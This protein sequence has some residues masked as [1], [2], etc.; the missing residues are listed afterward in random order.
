MKR[1]EALV[2]C[3]SRRK[4]VR[5]KEGG[6]GVSPVEAERGKGSG[7]RGV[8]VG[9]TLKR[10]RRGPDEAVP[11]GSRRKGGGL[12]RL[13]V[14]P[15]CGGTGSCG[16]RQH[17]NRGGGAYD[18]WAQHSSGRLNPVKPIQMIQTN[19]NSNFKLIQIWTDPKSTFLRAKKN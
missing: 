15:R 14:G 6:A 9:L 13:A 17:L 12:V 7:S 10:R 19:L 11:R 18:A 1:W 16:A 3:Q 8:P 4:R 2:R 5:T